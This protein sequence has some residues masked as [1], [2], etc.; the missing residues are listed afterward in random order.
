[1]VRARIGLDKKL[2][3]PTNRDMRRALNLR[4]I[5][6]GALGIAIMIFTVWGIGSVARPNDQTS[7][8]F[9]AGAVL[10]GGV[11]AWRSFLK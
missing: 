3:D 7:L 10:G 1:M 11:A 9:I 2:K 6:F 5:A 8:A 4:H